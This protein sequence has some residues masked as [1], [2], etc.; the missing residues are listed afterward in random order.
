MTTNPH[1]T[2]ELLYD[3]AADQRITAMRLFREWRQSVSVNARRHLAG[4]IRQHAALH[5][6]LLMAAHYMYAAEWGRP[7]AAT[8]REYRLHQV[9]IQRQAEAARTK[10]VAA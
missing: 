4:M 6:Q 7:P 5:R 3:C 9:R 1:I 10:E 2:T 8:Y